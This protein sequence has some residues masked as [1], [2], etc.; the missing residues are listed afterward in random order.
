MFVLSA[1]VYPAVLAL[2]CVGAGLAIDRAS[3]GF[4]PGVLLHRR[5]RGVTLSD[6]R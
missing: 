5:Q 4:L 6:E 3:G 2:L 1:L